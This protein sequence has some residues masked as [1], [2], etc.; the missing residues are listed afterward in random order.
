MPQAVPPG[1][2]EENDALVRTVQRA[3]FVEALALVQEIAKLAEAANHHPDIDIRYRTVRLALSTHSAGSKITDK[4][5]VLAQKIN[6]IGEA[7]IATATTDLR[8]RLAS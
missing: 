1:W 7:A 8:R 6:D 5:F 2:T 4:D 3:D